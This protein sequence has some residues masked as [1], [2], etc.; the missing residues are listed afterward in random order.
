MRALTF[1]FAFLLSA[2]SFSQESGAAKPYAH[3]KFTTNFIEKGL[4]QTEGYPAFQTTLGYKFGEQGILNFMGSNVAYPNQGS[5]LLIRGSGSYQFIFT[6]NFKLKP[7]L[8]YNKYFKADG[9]DGMAY[10]LELNIFEYGF[11]YETEANFEATETPRT[12]FGFAKVWAFYWGTTLDVEL[13]YSQVSATGLTSYFNLSPTLYYKI[14]L[15]DLGAGLSYNSASSTYEGQ[16]DL[17][18]FLEILATF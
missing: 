11:I 15:Y 8:F 1:L 6:P 3:L 2:P 7:F 4:S 10:G 13:G 5:H 16:G 14:N 9:R 12:Y 17:S 18:Y